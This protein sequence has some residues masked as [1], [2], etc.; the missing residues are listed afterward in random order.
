MPA[1]GDD[2]LTTP[3]QQETSAPMSFFGSSAET[4]LAAR[5]EEKAESGIA[6]WLSPLRKKLKEAKKN[7]ASMDELRKMLEK[8]K[9]NTHALSAAMAENIRKGFYEEETPN[10]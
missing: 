2:V 8:A 7:G 6:A 3:A 10:N 1:Q 5:T 9:L 4:A